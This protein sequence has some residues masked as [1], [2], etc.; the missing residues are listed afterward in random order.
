MNFTLPNGQV[1]LIDAEDSHLLSLPWRARKGGNK[2]Y[3]A[4][5]KRVDGKAKVFL[6]HRLVLGLGFDNPLSADH[7]NGNSLDNRRCNL[8]A[9]THAQNTLNRLISK[10]NTTGYK[11]VWREKRRFVASISLHGKRKRLGC[12]FTA[13][14]AAKAYDEA[15]LRHYGEF[16]C[17]NFPIAQN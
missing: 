2:F 8:R 14:D 3:V 16:A 6:M 13:E 5:Q 9:C 4:F 17:L 7:I 11:G 15:A 12:F 1:G 10:N